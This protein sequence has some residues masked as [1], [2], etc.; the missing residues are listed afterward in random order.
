MRCL[1]GSAPLR[2]KRLFLDRETVASRSLFS[3]L[4]EQPW[5][6]SLLVTGLVYAL[7]ALFSPL[8]G[9]AAALPFFGM[10]LYVLWLRLRRGPTLDAPALLQALRAASG[11]ELRTMLA[12]AYAREGYEIGDSA[13]GDLALTRQG[14]L[15]LVRY[16]RWRAQSTGAGAIDELARTMRRRSADRGI[17]VTAGSINEGARQ[18]ADGADIGLVDGSDLVRLL[19]RTRGARQALRRFRQ[20]EAK[21]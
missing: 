9:A 7:G 13:E 1:T 18:R 3:I 12:E 19:G 11:E 16:R 2:Y 8:V 5:W 15:T 17:Y 10:T 6:V 14:Y 20:E 4:T 21:S